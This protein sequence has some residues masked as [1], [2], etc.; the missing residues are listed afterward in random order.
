METILPFPS[1]ADEFTAWMELRPR[2]RLYD[3]ALDFIGSGNARSK[4]VCQEPTCG[5]RD[6]EGNL[7]S[8][9]SAQCGEKK[10]RYGWRASLQIG[11]DLRALVEGL[12]RAEMQRNAADDKKGKRS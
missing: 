4:M 9:A 1:D 6:E 12:E 8:C 11:R 5:A 2:D 10:M 3:L 7:I